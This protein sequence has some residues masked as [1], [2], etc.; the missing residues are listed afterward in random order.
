MKKKLIFIGLFFIALSSFGQKNPFLDRGYWKSNPSIQD[1][2]QKI[3]E[4][5]DISALTSSAFD[6]VSLALIEK[7][8]NKTIKYLLSKKGNGVNK[9]THDGRTYI[10]WAAYKDN[11][12][13]MKYLV[14]NGA[15]TDIIDSHGYSV[16]NFAA[17]TGQ[18]NTKL[19]DFCIQHGAKPTEE[20]N[21][22]GANALLLVAP[23]IKNVSLIDYFTSKGIDLKSTDN[24]GNGIFNYAAKTGNIQLM[25]YLVKQG[26][27]HKEPNKAGGNAMI[28]A[29]RGTRN[30]T[31]TL[32][33][34][35]YLE[36]LGVSPN[37]VTKEGITPLHSIAYR[38]KDI[39][40]FN[41][42]LSKGV[43]VNQANKSGNT[44]FL[45][46]A[47]LNNLSIVKFLS[48]HVKD[49]NTIDKEGKSALTNAITRNSVEVVEFSFRTRS[50]C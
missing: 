30:V 36:N 46:A 35:K 20:T 5:H 17:T 14:E 11:L 43:D 41:Y 8:D 34:Y 45:N 10:F 7:T 19:Y 29:S 33:T 39:G 6:A 9:L 31:N 47:L 16:L 23:F 37:V 18:L 32:E 44:P 49:I 13:M 24:Q 26:L 28:F 22:D 27:P 21:H 40:I 42:F 50:G 25:D 2:D 3:A 1:I 15:K 38:G 12:D 4:G 48:K